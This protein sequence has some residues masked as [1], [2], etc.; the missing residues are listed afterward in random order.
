MKILKTYKAVLAM[1]VT[2]G[3]LN[4]QVYAQP[5]EPPEIVDG[6]FTYIVDDGKAVITKFDYTDVKDVV[7]PAKLGGLTVVEID[8]DGYAFADLKRSNPTA[9][10]DAPENLIETVTIPATVQDISGFAFY[11]AEN[12]KSFIVAE[13]SEHFTVLDNVLY[14]KDMTALIAYPNGLVNEETTT[15]TVPDGVTFLDNGA[16]SY[17]ALSEVIFPSTLDAVGKWTFA[18]AQIEKVTIPKSVTGIQVAAFAYCSKLKI[19]EFEERR[20]DITFV[21]AAFSNCTALEEITI[22]EGV[23]MISAGTFERCHALKSVNLPSTLDEISTGA[24]MDCIALEEIEIPPSVTYIGENALGFNFSLQGQPVKN[25]RLT[26]IGVSGS[27]AEGYALAE[28][29]TFRAKQATSSETNPTG[30]TPSPNGNEGNKDDKKTNPVPFIAG[31][32]VVVIIGAVAL[33]ALQ[34][35]KLKAKNKSRRNRGK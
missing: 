32:M 12:I 21:S 9:N 15:F 33:Y 26:I 31:G 8:V 7:I 14:S 17:T 29:I 13:D 1:A 34:V 4:A 22:P 16:F 2:F 27:R 23:T 6:R 11:G 5:T 35:K 28:E 19:V 25:Q 30:T 3:I 18:H 20:K 24:F 10:P